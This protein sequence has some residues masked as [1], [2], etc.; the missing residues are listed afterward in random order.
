MNQYGTLI[1]YGWAEL[2]S[3]QVCGHPVCSGALQVTIEPADVVAAGAQWRRVGIT[4]WH[5]NGDSESGLASGQVIVEFRPIVGWNTPASQTITIVNGDMSPVTA[6]YTPQTGSLQIT[7]HPPEVVPQGAHWR[8]VGTTPWQDSG[9]VETNVPTGQ[10]TVEFSDIPN[11]LRPASFSVT[12][13]N[14]QTTAMSASYVMPPLIIVPP[15]SLTVTQGSTAQFT[16]VAIGTPP[17]TYQWTRNGV[18]LA[19][20]QS[21][22]LTLVNVTTND[23]GASFAVIMSNSGGSITSYPPAILTVVLGPAKPEFLSQPAD[24]QV[25]VGATA[26]FNA[27]VYGWPPP[28]FQ[29]WFSDTTNMESGQPLSGAT[30]LALTL[31]GV[32]T[33]E[34]GWYWLVATNSEGMATSRMANLTAVLPPEIMSQPS[35]LVVTQGNAAVFGV[36]VEGTPPF[37]Y[38][39]QFNGSNVAG[40]TGSTLNLTNVQPAQAGSYRVVVTNLAGMATSDAAMLDVLVPPT[41]SQHPQ[42]QT[43]CAGGNVTFTALASGTPAP[44]YQW[45]KDGVMMAGQTGNVLNLTDVQSG[46]AGMYDVVATNTAGTVTSAA[47]HLA[48]NLPPTITQQPSDQAATPGSSVQFQVIV[49]GGGPLSYQWRKD[50][51]DIPGATNAMLVLTDVQTNAAAGYS[52]HVAN[53]CGSA[54]STAA[55]LTVVDRS[56]RVVSTNALPGGATAVSIELVGDGT[57]NRAVFSLAFDR[58]TLS[59]LDVVS[60]SGATNATLTWSNLPNNELLLDVALP[61]NEVFSGGAQQLAVLSVTVPATITNT[62]VA[63]VS[64]GFV[65]QVL[66]AAGTALPYTPISGTVTITGSTAPQINSVSNFFEQTIEIAVPPDGVPSGQALLVLIYDLG[67][68]SQGRPIQVYNQS[69]TTNG[70]VPYLRLS[71][72]LAGGA[73]LPVTVQYIVPDWQTVPNP[74]FVVVPSPFVDTPVTG[75]PVAISSNMRFVDGRFYCQFQTVSGHTYYVQYKDHLDDPAWKTAGLPVTGTGGSV[76]WADTGLPKTSGAPKD[77][78]TRFYRVWKPNDRKEQAQT[79]CFLI[80]R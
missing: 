45:R 69:G 41:F 14:N 44:A 53:G 19:D 34:T 10:Y 9:Q 76:I 7:I 29:W 13:S 22:V 36:T 67:T 51:V 23:T 49:S 56:L 78:P 70:G 42:S 27:D 39:W 28:T 37:H 57:E 4:L 54:T 80:K 3:G 32:T 1:P 64:F 24:Q 77:A 65:G 17:P 18:S 48:V 40:A 72:P 43:L 25:P 59:L 47:A 50:G 61:T 6:T 60:G 75:T 79:A 2:L 52:V 66:D 55:T 12:I 20:T 16:V 11:W 33:N 5:N 46:D 31:T 30:G 74:R 15:V 62:T 21:N 35:D 38:Q 73:M 71:G 26:H 8:R 68:D 58:T 63:L